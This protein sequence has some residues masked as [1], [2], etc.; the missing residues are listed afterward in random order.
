MRSMQKRHR[1]VYDICNMILIMALLIVV[2]YP[3]WF[4]IIASISDPKLVSAGKVVFWPRGITLAGYK[5]VLEYAEIW[6]GY[7]NTLFYTGTG[8]ALNLA[9]TLPCAYALS[10]R[11]MYGRNAVMALFVVTMYFSGGLIPSYLN[12]R[13]FG[14]VDTP[15]VLLICGMVSTY[16]LIVSRTFFAGLPWEIQEAA[17]IDGCNDFGVFGAIVLPLSMPIVAVMGLYYGVGHWNEYFNAMVYLRTR[18]LYPLQSFLKEILMQSK[19]AETMLATETMDAS[20]L[21]ALYEQQDL[22]NLLKYCTIIISTLP[23]LVLYPRMQV[24]FEK[25]VMIGALKG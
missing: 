14:L 21:M 11:D 13:D 8:T 10:R 3:V 25:G 22:A 16:N 17:R 6:R 19:L 9:V 1:E 20:G 5:K 15:W 24:F 12:M 2:V 18:S 23:M 7:A 4:V